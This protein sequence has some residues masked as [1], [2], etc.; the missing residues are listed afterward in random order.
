MVSQFHLLLA[1]HIAKY[2]RSGNRSYLYKAIREE[3]IEIVSQK[4][5]EVIV[6]K[7]KASGYF[8]VSVDLTPDIWQIEQLSVV[9]RY[10][11]DAHLV[12][13]DL[14]AAAKSHK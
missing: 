5:Y 12:L 6:K 7:V 13:F 3:I 8:S 2:G 4:V 14:L 9:L 1:P 10:V 11:V